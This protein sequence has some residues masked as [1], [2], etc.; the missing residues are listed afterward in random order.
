MILVTV[1][2]HNQP[3]DRLVRAADELALRL[4]ERVIVQRGAASYLPRFAHQVDYVDGDQMGRWLS[5]CRVLVS[6]C[7]C[8]SILSALQS[9]KPLVLVPRLARLDEHVDD[10]QFELAEAL[11][12]RGRA[13]MVTQLSARTLAEAVEEAAQLYHRPVNETGL[14]AALREWLA[15]QDAQPRSRRWRLLLNGGGG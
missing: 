10:H 13:A 15:E 2:M 9:G 14:H 7:G 5:E 4:N 3:F 11:I 12:E 1:G 6:H 8:G